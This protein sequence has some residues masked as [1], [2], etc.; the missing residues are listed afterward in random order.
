MRSI[1]L[2][3]RVVLVFLS[4]AGPLPAQ[5]LP[6]AG[7]APQ[8]PPPVPPVETRSLSP[9]HQAQ[10]QP[11]S[12]LL[13]SIGDPTDDEQQYLEF[14]NRSRANPPAEG[15]RLATTTDSQV[16]SAYTYFGVDT[17]QMELQFAAI[18]AAPPVA[19]NGNLIASARS[20][21][22]WMLANNEQCHYED[23]PFGCPAGVGTNGPGYRA[24]AYGYVWS[25]IG[26]NIYASS[27]SDW[28]GHA[29]F[30]VDWGSGSYGMQSPPGH[31]QN[32]ANASFREVGIGVIYGSNTNVGPQ[33]VA[34]DFGAQ[35]S[36]PPLVTGAAY[37]DLN[38]NNNYDVGEG[39][40]GV[41]V[42]VGGSSYYAV[43]SNSGGYAV[44]AA[45]GAVTVS[46]SGPGLTTVTQLVTITNGANVKVD[47]VPAYSPSVISGAAQPVVSAG[48]AYTFTAVGG[49]TGYQWMSVQRVVYT[50]MEGAEFGLTNVSLN[51]STGYTVLDSTIKNSGNYSFHFAQ[52]DFKPQYLMLLPRFRARTNAALYFATRLAYS[53]DGQVARAQ[54]STNAGAIW[55][56][57]WNET[58][59]N[60]PG[61]GSFT[62]RTNSLAA[63]GGQQFMV[64]FVYDYIS[65]GGA[66]TNI[67][68]APPVGFY[69]DDISF[70]NAEQ[71]VNVTTNV[72][73][74]GTNF[75][76]TPTAAA[77]YS[78]YVQPH[79]SNRYLNF[80]PELQ[81]VAAAGAPF[82]RLNQITQPVPGQTRIDFGATNVTTATFKLLQAGQVNGAWTTN[83]SATLAT[84]VPGSSYRFTTT[85]GAAMQYYRVQTP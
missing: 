64:R 21:S 12:L 84:N 37:Y 46:F 36:P 44:P 45:N 3:C 1:I 13:Y 42:N 11:L 31:R 74:G 20:H 40:G 59:T 35:S 2:T 70:T 81:V 53:G 65:S 23:I 61:E 22:A 48:N 66:Y 49:A 15:V 38:G 33:L 43:T 72:V 30:N 79:I 27:S 71:L 19:F 63:Y 28:Y 5:L 83:S 7:P 41:T 60:G 76:F 47:F 32:I 10:Q 52:P 8:S 73:A 24:T 50:N 25:T 56:D 57:V 58:G 9:L 54:L 17:N 18:A 6:V 55:F 80:G 78:L 51:V 69:L 39:L 14:I 77:D 68:D 82:I 75:T 4:V 67:S 34:E 29:G 26:E 16:L 62:R 85:N